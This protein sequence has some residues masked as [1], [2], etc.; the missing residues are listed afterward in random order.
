MALQAPKA[1]KAEP[2]L[3]DKKRKEDHSYQFPD[4]GW[5]CSKCQN[6]N[7]KGRKNCH[8]CKK[9]KSTDDFEGKPEHMLVPA[10][11]KAAVKAKNRKR[12]QHRGENEKD[13][14]E[15]KAD[16]VCQRCFNFNYSLRT[17]CN[18]CSMPFSDN[19]GQ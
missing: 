18:R 6:Y 2:T 15:P 7:F 5:E 14:A 11:E 12:R 13:G 8:R 10:P 1:A 19:A 4:G 9:P 17:V 16:W 3:T